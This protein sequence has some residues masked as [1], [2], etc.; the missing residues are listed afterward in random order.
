M[1][2]IVMG[3][4]YGSRLKPLTKIRA[5]P[6]VGFYGLSILGHTMKNIHQADNNCHIMIGAQYEAPKLEKKVIEDVIKYPEMGKIS[7]EFLM[8]LH[9][10][11]YDN[12][13]KFKSGMDATKRIYAYMKRQGTDFGNRGIGVH[14]ADGLTTAHL[15]ELLEAHQKYKKQH[16][17]Q[18]TIATKRIPDK[19]RMK[20]F[21][22]VV[23]DDSKVIGFFEKNNNPPSNIANITYYVIEPEI[24]DIMLENRYTD[25]KDLFPELA[26]QNKIYQYQFPDD[27]FWEDIAS[28]SH[29]MSSYT[30]S[31]E[32]IGSKISSNHPDKYFF[33]PMADESGTGKRLRLSDY[34]NGLYIP[35]GF[36]YV[37]DSGLTFRKQ[38]IRIVNSVLSEQTLKNAIAMEIQNA[39]ISNSVIG[40]VLNGKNFSLNNSVIVDCNYLENCT[41]DHSY[42]DKNADVNKF[43]ENGEPSVMTN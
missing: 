34:S 32:I 39:D 22:S 30:Y 40:G 42:F 3:G 14:T 13:G 24:M 19:C 23:S 12:C 21:G 10:S 16:D 33:G 5:K 18:V 26:K 43:W 31:L 2:H 28:P 25:F 9:L 20:D 41:I 8:P 6:A 1:Y 37:K 7:Y 35:E 11:K 36:H 17:A 38:S 15:S 4:G 29:L 27:I